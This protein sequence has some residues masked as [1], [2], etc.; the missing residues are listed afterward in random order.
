[1]IPRVQN[2]HTKDQ[3]YKGKKGNSNQKPQSEKR[4][5]EIWRKKG[6]VETSKQGEVRNISVREA[7]KKI[8]FSNIQVNH[9]AMDGLEGVQLG[10]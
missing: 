2:R 4:G 6:I 9:L 5:K 1:M 10:L 8:Q 7:Y 3:G